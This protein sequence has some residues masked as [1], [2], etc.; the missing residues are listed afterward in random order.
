MKDLIKVWF[1]LS[2]LTLWPLQ[3]SF[4]LV[5]WERMSILLKFLFGDHFVWTLTL[6]YIQV[7]LTYGE[8]RKENLFIFFDS[9]H[10][11]KSVFTDFTGW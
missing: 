7:Q 10:W 6:L 9:S 1:R 8:D 2:A 5:I 3:V 4:G 11:M